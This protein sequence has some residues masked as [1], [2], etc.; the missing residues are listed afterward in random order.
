MRLWQAHYSIA[1]DVQKKFFP[2]KKAYNRWRID[3]T[4]EEEIYQDEFEVMSITRIDVPTK[5]DEL[6]DF[7]NNLVGY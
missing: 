6:I 7:L 5:K 2:S 1:G 4:P 3:N